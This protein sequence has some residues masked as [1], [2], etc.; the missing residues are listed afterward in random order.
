MVKAK[1]EVKKESDPAAQRKARLQALKDKAV[2]RRTEE[3]EGDADSGD[4][5]NERRRELMKL[6]GRKRQGGDSSGQGRPGLGRRF[7][8][9]GLEQTD[10]QNR[11][12]LQRLLAQ[13]GGGG[14]GFGGAG[15]GMGAG[16]GRGRGAELQPVDASNSPEEIAE[17]QSELINRAVRLNKALSHI[18]GELARVGQL[19]SEAD[20]DDDVEELGEES[21]EAATEDNAAE[22]KKSIGAESASAKRRVRR[23]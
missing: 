10:I 14:G 15:G 20:A 18:I 9:G 12:G 13:R 8:G 22:K 1:T 5:G 3:G 21:T 19:L 16:L 2:A 11:P 23:K 6:L 7:G 4:D 17:Y